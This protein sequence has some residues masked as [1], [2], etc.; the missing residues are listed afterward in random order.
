MSIRLIL[1]SESSRVLRFHFWRLMWVM[2]VLISPSSGWAHDYV[3]EKSYWTDFSDEASFDQA[4]NANYT[5]YRGVL[6]KG[7]SSHAQWIRLKIDGA[8]V[9]SASTLVL[10][11]R[12]VFLDRI[13]IYDP[14]ELQAGKEPRVT[15]DRTPLEST[16]FDSL[17][18]IFVISAQQHPRYIWL[19]LNTTSTQL[20]QVEALL[21][22]EM[23]REEHALWLSYSALLATL[24]SCILW[25]A[26]S[27]LQD[28]DPVNGAFVVRQSVLF[29]YTAC[30]LGYHR[31]LLEGVLSAP[32]QDLLYCWVLLMTTCL[33][34]VFEFRFLSEFKI[35]VWG[36]QALRACICVSAGLMLLLLTGYRELAL[37]G[38][39]TL[40]GVGVLLMLLTAVG[41][42]QDG[43]EIMNSNIKYRLPKPFILGYYS[44]VLFVLGV[45]IMPGLGLIEGST[46]SIYGVL[47]YGLLSGIFMA[48]LL[49]VRSR[50]TE[51]FRRDQANRLYLSQEQLTL[52]KSRRL[53]QSQLLN[54]L[55]HEL[56][57]P[58]AVI[59]MAIRDRLRSDKNQTYVS[60]AVENMKSILNRCVQTDR[61]VD[62]SLDIQLQHFDLAVQ[63]QQWIKDNHQ[64][65]ERIQL[66][67][68][69]MA[70]VLSDMQCVQIIVTNLIE[71]ALKY[72]D[73]THNV[74]ITLGWINDRAEQPH[75]CLKVQNLVGPTGY[76]DE[77]RLFEKY[78]RSAVAQRQSGTGLGLYLS[79]NL[80]T[81]LGGSLSYHRVEN[82]ICFELCLPT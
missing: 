11:I 58:L 57:T 27:W 80:A 73:Q 79:H 63:L 69:P 82:H 8:P 77:Q 62:R 44:F 81:Q 40:T 13:T 7:F 41:I 1:M 75:V 50:Q 35:P 48:G 70:I 67:C 18:H 52:E 34:F 16:D 2:L 56:K 31:V 42:E 32:A 45:S 60:R 53:D 47:L 38:N 24:L 66:L 36:K 21:P 20:I 23:L 74:T 15:G 72:S 43:A 37:L 55:M 78:Y 14:I 68:P 54:M 49:I 51:R 59:E 19:R 30:Y 28:R 61:M 9:D 64:F 3:L 26:I 5:A 10:R 71:N 46:L 25:V 76:P 6:S 39:T 65:G 17:N 4:R 22:R 29:I 33:T 12:P